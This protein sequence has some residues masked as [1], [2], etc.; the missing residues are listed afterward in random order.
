MTMIEI[1]DTNAMVTRLRD[2]ER[3]FEKGASV[4]HATRE[5]LNEL[6]DGLAE[7]GPLELGVTPEAWLSSISSAELGIAA[8]DDSLSAKA[9]RQSE[10]SIRELRRFFGG[11]DDLTWVDWIVLLVFLPFLPM[12]L[13]QAVCLSPFWLPAVL[14]KAFKRR[15]VPDVREVATGLE[16]PDRLLFAHAV[17][18]SRPEVGS[19]L[20]AKLG[21]YVPP[22]LIA[23]DQRLVLARPPSLL[24][25]QPG[26]F[27][28]AWDVPYSRIRSFS[29]RTVAGG[30]SEVVT[31]Q[32]P[33]R[34]I[35]YK[36]PLYEG[37]A[38]VAILKRR[39]AEAFPD[40]VASSARVAVEAG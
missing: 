16:L 19:A 40:S 17:K 9:V 23:T 39:A 7:S 10:Q 28:V 3:R 1:R 4:P 38:M 12:A 2:A 5:L 6:L 14:I 35:T 31:V 18:A 30:G 11:S 32:T 15:H 37:T 26:Q 24:P 8:A 36:L 33:E 29:S 13:F 20:R 34:E 22:V 27:A 21:A 25:R